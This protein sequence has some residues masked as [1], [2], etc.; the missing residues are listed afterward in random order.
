MLRS[1]FLP[2]KNSTHREA[3][4]TTCPSLKEIVL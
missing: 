1:V 2:P 3:F 4:M